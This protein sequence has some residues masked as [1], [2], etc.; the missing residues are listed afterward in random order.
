MTKASFKQQ[1]KYSQHHFE[2]CHVEQ[3]KSDEQTQTHEMYV[4]WHRQ[5]STQS[6]MTYNVWTYAYDQL[7]RATCSMT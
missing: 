1:T 4:L 7:R 2:H 5:Q 3:L 6:Y